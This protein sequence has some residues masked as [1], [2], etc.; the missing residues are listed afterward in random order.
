MSRNDS[1]EKGFSTKNNAQLPS[2]DTFGNSGTN[3]RANSKDNKGQQSTKNLA[4]NTNSYG[5]LAKKSNPK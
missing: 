4:S 5:T 3:F 2:K 1:E